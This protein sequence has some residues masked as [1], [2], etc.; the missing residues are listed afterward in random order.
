MI[1]GFDNDV[2]LENKGLFQSLYKVYEP[3]FRSQGIELVVMQ[4]NMQQFRQAAMER[5]NLHLTFGSPLTA[6]ALVLGNMFARFYIPASYQYSHLVP[7]GSHPILD[8]LLST[9]TMQI[10]HDGAGVSRV[11]KTIALA[12]WPDTHSRLRVCFRSARYDPRRSI[13]ENCGACEKCLRTMIPLEVAGLLPK[14][15]TFPPAI[16]PRSIRRIRYI[17]ESSRSFALENMRYAL[18][19]RRWGLAASLA[20]VVARGKL[21]AAFLHPLAKRL[22]NKLRDWVKRRWP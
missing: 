21:Y 11:A 7:D 1:N 3:M 2:D 20:Y 8:H 6:S 22:P 14:F 13:F 5:G 4:T 17:S 9:E 18:H 15:P 12:G 19:A 10:I 16:S